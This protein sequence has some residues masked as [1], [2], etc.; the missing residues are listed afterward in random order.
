MVRRKVCSR[1]ANVAVQ[2]LVLLTGF[3]GR[4]GCHDGLEDYRIWLASPPFNAHMRVPVRI[5]YH[6]DRPHEEEAPGGLENDLP[7]PG[8]VIL[9]GASWAPS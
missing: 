7:W 6:L 1:L 2:L 3:A 4:A 5:I 8:D 9:P